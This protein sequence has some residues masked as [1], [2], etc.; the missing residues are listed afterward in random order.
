MGLSKPM[1]PRRTCTSSGVAV[2]PSITPAGSP[3]IRCMR[4]KTSTDAK[5]KVGTM[6]AMLFRRY[7]SMRTFLRDEAR[8]AP[9]DPISGNPSKGYGLPRPS[10]HPAGP[11]NPGPGGSVDLLLPDVPEIREVQHG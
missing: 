5:R 7:R 9:S 6:L 11:G 10:A 3:G 2:S 8:Y 1:V 4:E